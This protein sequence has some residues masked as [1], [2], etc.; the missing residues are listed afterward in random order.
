M[1]KK[2]IS[3]V[4]L[5]IVLLTVVVVL[6]KTPLLHLNEE[7]ISG[8]YQNFYITI[9]KITK[10]EQILNHTLQ[11]YSHFG[12]NYDEL[13]PLFEDAFEIRDDYNQETLEISTYTQLDYFYILYLVTN[14]K[15]EEA[16]KYIDDNLNGNNLNEVASALST[17]Y[18][19]LDEKEEKN[20][21]LTKTKEVIESDFYQELIKN[22]YQSGDLKNA[23][24]ITSW[25]FYAYALFDNGS[26]DE[27]IK[28]IKKMSSNPNASHFIF[29]TLNLV[30]DNDNAQKSEFI[31]EVI[32]YLE[33]NDILTKEEIIRL[34][35]LYQ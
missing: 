32:E 12:N 18:Y 34:K 14:D 1:K 21:S 27:S 25:S 33:N 30:S 4:V 35:E 31:D 16:D 29:A 28:E 3:A 6:I 22:E 17:I 2:L 13:K 20:W 5:F 9:Y 26:Y 24:M 23:Y 19:T 10:S 15:I 11:A 7:D 8:K